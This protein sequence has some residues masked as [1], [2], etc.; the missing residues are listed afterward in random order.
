MEKTLWYT[1]PLSKVYKKLKAN[2]FGLATEEVKK[3]LKKYGYNSLPREKKLSRI[4]I[5]LSQFKNPLI[6]VL[7]GAATISLILQNFIDMSVILVA[8]FINAI[9]GFYQ[10]NKANNAISKLRKLIDFKAIVIRDNNETEISTTKLVP[11]D[12]IVLEAGDKIPADGRLIS[13]DNFQVIESALTGESVPSVKNNKFFSKGTT[14]ADRKN[15]IY[16]G[17]VVASGRAKAIIC[18]TGSNTQL[19]QISK[20]IKEVK[21]DQTPLQKQLD[22]FSKT[23]T[24]IVLAICAL[25]IIIG[26]L[27]GRPIFGFGE[28]S[29]EG[30]LNMA[31]AIAV[32]AIPEGLI[33]AVTAILA[34]G[35]QSILKRK[36]LVR[37]LVAAETLGSVSV[38]CTDK[39]GTLTEGKMQVSSIISFDQEVA[40]NK[41]T[42]F[43][44]TKSLKDKDLIIKISLL[45]NNASIENPDEAL[46]NWK[47][48]GSPTEGA[49]LL[50]AVQAGVP[51]KLVNEQQPRLAEI[52][53][54]SEFKYMA[55]LNKLNKNNNVVYVKGAPEKIIAMSTKIRINH[56]TEKLTPSK[57]K[58]LTTKYE[59]LT[60]QGLRLLAFGYKQI[61]ADD[62]TNLKNELTNLTF[63]GFIALKDPLRPE[64]KATFEL[65][66]KAGIR[67]IIITG[68]HKLTAK[69]VVSEL[70]IKVD[71]ENIIE[72]Y[73][74]D[75]I[76]D[77]DLQKKVRT[78]DVYARVEPRHK[79]RIIEALQN[80]GEVVAMT[81][82][83]VND[84]PAIKAADIGIALGSGTDVAKETADIILLDNNFKTIVAAV[85]RGRVI[86]DNIRKVI[87]YLLA[88]S[89]SEIILITGALLLF[90]P[91]P[92]LPAQIIWI[93]LIT[94]GFPSLALTFEPGEKEVMKDKPRKKKSKILDKEM[95]ILI[96]VIGIL[97]DIVLLGFFYLLLKLN[98]FDIDHIRT[99][100][101]SA[102]A[103]DSLLYVFSC[104][105]LRHT[106]LTKNPFSNKFLVMA[107][108]AGLALQMLAVYQPHLQIIFKTVN[109][110]LTDWLIIIALS[111]VKFF[112]IEITKYYFIIKQSRV[113]VNA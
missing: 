101:F 74:L 79:L 28:Q 19:G 95:K 93:N 111:F 70:G 33:V 96:F 59:K 18:A 87:L 29:R 108:L 82:D 11:G 58:S 71:A 17:T 10:E 107:V 64:A 27:Q 89:F 77:K 76:S 57:I 92:L 54:D 8:V 61:K 4:A 35:M 40:I 51:Y 50:G 112:G 43:D 47:I 102:L 2:K 30:M 48:L 109:L 73:Q 34:I 55:T 65:T 44:Q 21:E 9:L 84:A 110:A 106:I 52:P 86:F 100:M 99:L 56:Q 39:T 72:G 25:I 60:N 85:E 113:K 36:A 42:K 1:I 75:K 12:V 15:M 97:T 23:L 94:D 81:G 13:F 16:S 6:Y 69:A 32:A 62:K 45:C 37:K 49:L 26:K 68:D 41:S 103:L 80:N 90:L 105:S 5:L 31:A 7:I 91:L 83:G 104:R 67:L 22:K 3:R 88:D 38:I 78:I 20:L 24:V 14:L 46:E 98:H 63:V 53:F 66:K